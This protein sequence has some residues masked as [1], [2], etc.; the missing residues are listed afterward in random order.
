MSTAVDG[1]I[2]LTW[3]VHG[4]NPT[5]IVVERRSQERR[6]DGANTGRTTWERVATLS[7]AANEYTD[8]RAPKHAAYRVR[9]INHDGESAYSNVA[10]SIR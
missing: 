5:G 3:E 6:T 8:S 1:G 7:P 10:P 2:R 4:G 9:A